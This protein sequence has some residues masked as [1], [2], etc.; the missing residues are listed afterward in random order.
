MKNKIQT[1]I[2]YLEKIHRIRG[3]IKSRFS[4]LR[5]DKNEKVNKF[6]FTF[7]SKILKRIKSEHLTAYPEVEN[8]YNLISK[9]D[10][11][12]KRSIVL[13]AGSD[14]AIRTC[15][16]FFVEK[17][18]KIITIE[19]TFAMVNIYSKIFQTKQIRISFDRNLNFNLSNL[20]KSIKKNIDLIILANPN[21]PTGTL[22]KKNE[23][24]IILKKSNKFN[25]PVL[26]DEAYYGFCKITCVPL[27]KKYK[28]LIVSRTF[29]K[30][31]GVAGVRV[32]YLIASP[33]I[34]NILYKLKPMYEIN[35]IGALISEELIKNKIDKRYIKE[36]EKGKNLL[37]KY[38]ILNNYEFI[39]THANFIHINF[40]DKFQLI[41]KTFMKKNIL[42][43]GGP[44]VKGFEN[45]LR[46]TLGSPKDMKKVISILKIFKD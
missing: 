17:G 26:I 25:V 43:K 8:L 30:A 27:I 10:N 21:S 1:K 44:Q 4:F 29:S 9:K 15:F 31:Y 7:L 35:S 36:V 14:G 6:N 22:I 16:D 13:T 2:R 37:Q 24:E 39:I 32:G 20:L 41:K 46:I 12:D 3:P 11:V 34:A 28:N 40:E 18:S 19:P 38:L 33:R 42:V 5:L 45:F 23:L